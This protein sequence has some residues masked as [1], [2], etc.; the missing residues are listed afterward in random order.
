[1]KQVYTAIATMII[2]GI[3]QADLMIYQAALTNE[4]T[5][6]LWYTTA[7]APNNGSAGPSYTLGVQAGA[8]AA[9]YWGNANSAFGISEGAT[10]V[11]AVSK[12]TGLFASGEKG[13]VCFLFKTP[14]NLKGLSSLF[15]QG[16]ASSAKPFEVSI[17]EGTLRLGTY[18][19][20]KATTSLG[21]LREG[22][23]YYFAMT[24]DLSR[25]SGNLTWY[26]GEAGTTLKSDS[27]TVTSAGA[28][29]KSIQI[30]GRNSSAFFSGGYFQ[31]VAVYE[32]YLS[33]AEIHLQFSTL[34]SQL[35]LG[36]RK[37]GYL[38]RNSL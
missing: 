38:I 26:Y 1:M 12:S 7:R 32:T 35:T 28:S 24:W 27:L 9:D 10:K 8:S 33:D 18:N 4:A 11:S 14:G 25:P 16:D 30:G 21:T 34:T 29:D 20:S 13:T 31:N 5:P 22:A 19:N 3:T 2:T 17:N 6:A 37:N 23:W 15:N 36:W